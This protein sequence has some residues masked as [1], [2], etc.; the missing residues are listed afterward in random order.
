MTTLLLSV[1]S[2]H[3]SW[4]YWVKIYFTPSIYSGSLKVK[5]F[6]CTCYESVWGSE[7]VVPF[8]KWSDSKPGCFS[9]WKIVSDIHVLLLFLLLQQFFQHSAKPS[10]FSPL[11]YR[12]FH[13]HS[14]ITQILIWSV[15]NFSLFRFKLRF[16]NVCSKMK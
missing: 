10:S 2:A 8:V 3:S 16:I 13:S 6:F 7:G 4:F 15:L 14:N 5:F 12:L 1:N 11:N 9:P